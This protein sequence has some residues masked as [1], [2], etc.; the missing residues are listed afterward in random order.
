MNTSLTEEHKEKGTTLGHL[1]VQELLDEGAEPLKLIVLAGQSGL[2]R[3]II[4]KEIHRPGLALAGFLQLFSF[5]RVQVLGNTEVHYLRGLT[6]SDRANATK[7]V[8]AHEIPCLILPNSNK[9]GKEL[10]EEAE[11]AKIPILGSEHSTTDLIN[12]LSTYLDSRF[13]PFISVHSSLVDVYGSGLLITG[14]SGIGKSEVALDLVERG[15]RLVADDVVRIEK[16]AE[17]L[18]IGSS[19]EMIRHLI[20]IRGVGLIDVRRM[21]GVRGIRMQKRVEVEVR[22]QEWDDNVEWERIGLD[23]ENTS[24]LGV[25]IPLVRLPIFPGKNI[26]MI[27][28]VIALNV[29][30]KVYGFSAAEELEKRMHEKINRQNLRRYLIRDYE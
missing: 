21:F 3:K 4:E 17:G 1:K 13:A 26:S 11:R 16:K 23:Q 27:A 14:R 28:E 25:E 7:S 18:L 10:V 15:H 2:S 9:P 22:L 20:E 19:P 8:M 5:Q 30:L 12:L 6:P 24:Y 29:H